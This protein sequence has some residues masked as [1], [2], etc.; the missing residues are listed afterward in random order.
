MKDELLVLTGL[1][2]DNGQANGDGPGDH[3]RSLAAFLTGA[4]PLKTDGADIRAGISV[5]Q[6][7]AREVGK[8]DPVPLAGAGL[9]RGAQAGNCDS[10]L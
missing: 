4:H 9:E 6:V 10:G 5:D 2:Q 7:A 3:A 1:A 8:C